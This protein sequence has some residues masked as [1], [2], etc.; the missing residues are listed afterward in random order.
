MTATD[1]CLGVYELLETILLSLSPT[2]LTRSMRVSTTWKQMIE[3]SQR[4]QRARV[5]SPSPTAFTADQ[6][7]K[8]LCQGI[9][10]YPISVALELNPYLTSKTSARDTQIWLRK[11]HIH[12]LRKHKHEFATYPRCERM[13]LET[14][15][16]RTVCTIYV[17]SGIRIKDLLEVSATL[18]KTERGMI[19]DVFERV[20]WDTVTRLAGCGVE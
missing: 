20:S 5:V 4:L 1:T 15:M 16:A 18:W 8:W 14:C 3:Q 13:Q 12:T 7:R 19:F 6:T 11:K 10:N 2:D 9:P 17:K